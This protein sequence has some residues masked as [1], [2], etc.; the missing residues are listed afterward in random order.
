MT[1]APR[2]ISKPREEAD[3][4]SE[5]A[6]S[7]VAPEAGSSACGGVGVMVK[8]LM[9]AGMSMKGPTV[10]RSKSKN[11]CSTSPSRSGSSVVGTVS[12]LLVIHRQ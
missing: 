3:E 10:P 1:P 2:V 5:A 9:G 12:P 8:G 6:A 4:D 11:A 7:V